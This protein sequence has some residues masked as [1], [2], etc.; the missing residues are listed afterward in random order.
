MAIPAKS[1]DTDWVFF[2]QN[3]GILALVPVVIYGFL[4]FFRRLSVTTAYEYLEYRF[5]VS[6][7]LAGSAIYML[8]QV[9]NIE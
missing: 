2:V 1:Y 5:H 7:R 6:L 8:F 3:L 9:G 4:P